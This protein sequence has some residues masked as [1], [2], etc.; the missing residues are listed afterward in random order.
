MDSISHINWE[1][2]EQII[3]THIFIKW[4][5]W[6]QTKNFDRYWGRAIDNQIKNIKKSIFGRF[7]SPC[8]DC[9]F[10]LGDGKC[11]KNESGAQTNECDLYAKWEKKKKSGYNLL[12]A[13]STNETFQDDEQEIRFE[14]AG[15]II[16]ISEATKRLHKLMMEKLPEKLAKFYKMRYIDG[17]EDSVISFAFGFMTT[18]EGRLPGY[19]QLYNMEVEV[20]ELATH[21]VYSEDVF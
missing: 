21:I 1:D 3:R 15:G 12:L 10:N 14:P 4:E 13:R 19:R 20:R 18:E 8:G 7:V 9:K 6:D 2:V 16:N 17:L 5:K 11:A